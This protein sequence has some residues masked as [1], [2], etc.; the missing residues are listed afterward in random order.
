MPYLALVALVPL[1]AAVSN[2]SFLTGFVAGLATPFVPALILAARLVPVPHPGPGEPNW[3]YAGFLLFGAILGVLGGI[4][5]DT[6]KLSFRQVL[7]YT[8]A[9]IALEASLLGFLPVHLALSQ[10]RV[11]AALMLASVTGI[12][13]VSAVL[14]F[15]NL[16][17]TAVLR[18]RGP[19]WFVPVGWVVVLLALMQVPF[20]KPQTPTGLRVAI[21]QTQSQEL[22]DLRKLNARA[23][24]LGA[25]IAVWPELSALAAAP[26]GNTSSLQALSKEPGQPAF[27]TSFEDAE[28]PRPHHTAAL[29]SKGTESVRYFKRRPFAGEITVHQPGSIAAIAAWDVPVGLNVCFDSCHPGIMRETALLKDVGLIA[30]PTEDP[31]SMDA[32]IQSLH[33]AYTPF[34]SAEL[35][36]TIARADITADSMIVGP[37]GRILAELGTGEDVAAA[38][39]PAPRPTFYKSAGDWFLYLCF[40]VVLGA[41]GFSVRGKL[42]QRTKKKSVGAQTPAP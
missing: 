36:M 38:D 34:R 6:K 32:I 14:W 3:I 23:S 19:G 18:A 28:S 29:F 8:A 22:A 37:D 33:A 5:A 4:L 20:G 24:E 40:V 10:S 9:S 25:K 39:V 17:F 7:I 31:V 42:Q 30:L 21:I 41:I 35:G 16:W 26:R 2:T 27:V 15:T 13:G 11:P 1:M 12:W